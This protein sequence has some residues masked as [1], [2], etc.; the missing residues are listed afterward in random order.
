MKILKTKY[1]V[2]FGV[3]IIVAVLYIL[4]LTHMINHLPGAD[5]IIIIMV[6]LG[7]VSLFLIGNSIEMSIKE[8]QEL[9]KDVRFTGVIGESEEMPV[10]KSTGNFQICRYIV[11]LQR[12]FKNSS[13]M[14]ELLNRLLVASSRITHSERASI[15]LYDHKKDELYVYK[16]LGWGANEIQMIKNMRSKPGEGIAGRVFLDGKPRF[17]AKFEDYEGVEQ[18]EKYRSESFISLPIISDQNIIGV[19]NLTEKE[20]GEY[21]KVEQELLQF[22]INEVDAALQKFQSKRVSKTTL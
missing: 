7:L 14:E 12:Y 20:D 3:T 4:S 11:G 17:S 1:L 9:R 8:V 18:R 10:L 21:S 13:D 16:T 6:F 22:M 19:L 15:M 5:N 2:I